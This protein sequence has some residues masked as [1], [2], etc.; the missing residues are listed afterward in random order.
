[1]VCL[2]CV[3]VVYT[4]VFQLRPTLLPVTLKLVRFVA[5][6][7]TKLMCLTGPEARVS[8]L[9]AVLDPLMIIP[10]QQQLVNI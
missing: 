8:H 10:T 5:T 9:V 6:L 7:R 4:C 1:M 2:L 3:T